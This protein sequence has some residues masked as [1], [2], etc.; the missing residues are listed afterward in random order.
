M[1][2]TQLAH[3]R[4]ALAVA[5]AS[6]DSSRQLV[7]EAGALAADAQQ[8]HASALQQWH[9]DCHRAELAKADAAHAAARL[10]AA[11]QAVDDGSKAPLPA[12]ELRLR[13]LLARAEAA[14]AETARLHS[15]AA[16][17]VAASQRRQE[18]AVARHAAARRTLQRR[19]EEL[20]QVLRILHRA[21]CTVQQHSRLS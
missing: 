21:Y 19:L 2:P 13:D 3:A 11:R 15:Q 6:T 17:V 14:A 4:Q 8:A 16:A 5:T 18:Q 12:E 20:E 7:D 9:G 10:Q 1:E